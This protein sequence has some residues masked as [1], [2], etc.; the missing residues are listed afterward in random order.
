MKRHLRFRSVG[1]LGSFLSFA[2]PLPPTRCPPIVC[3]FTPVTI[4]IFPRILYGSFASCLAAGEPFHSTIY[5]GLSLLSPDNSRS[6]AD[7]IVPFNVPRFDEAFAFHIGSL[8]NTVRDYTS[9]LTLWLIKPAS[10]H[11]PS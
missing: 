4:R 11:P 1:R 3:N 10:L 6:W 2:L 7:P 5:Y 8:L 9:H